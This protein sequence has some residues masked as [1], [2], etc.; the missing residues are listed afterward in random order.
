MARRKSFNEYRTNELTLPMGEW[1]ECYGNAARAVSQFPKRLV[2]VEGFVIIPNCAPAH[3]AWCVDKVTG[4]RHE[5]TPGYEE[6]ESYVHIGKEF[7]KE[8][9]R[10]DRGHS[11]L[12]VG[13]MFELLTTGAGYNAE[14]VA[15]DTSDEK[16]VKREV[17]DLRTLDLYLDWGEANR[18]LEGEWWYDWCIKEPAAVEAQPVLDASAPALSAV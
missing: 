7:T 12:T 6:C 14:L 8:E 18:Q 15:Y 11:Q 5:L 13:E 16:N 2:Y 4:K 3:H 1:A 17:V 9:F 10:N